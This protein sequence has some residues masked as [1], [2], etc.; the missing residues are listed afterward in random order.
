MVQGFGKERLFRNTNIF[1]GNMLICRQPLFMIYPPL[2][3]YKISV[4]VCM[5]ASMI[6]LA[7]V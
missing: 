5:C 1:L 3:L 2:F 7:G 4:H 6:I